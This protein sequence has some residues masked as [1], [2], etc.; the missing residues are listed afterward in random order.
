LAYPP[1]TGKPHPQIV[2]YTLEGD[3]TMALSKLQGKKVLLVHFASWSEE[4]R[5]K[6]PAWYEKTKQLV[7]DGKLVVLGVAHEQHA[8]RCR[9]FAQWKGINWPI[10]HDPLNLIRV[11][12]LPL[13]IGIDEHGIVR[14]DNLDLDTFEDT[15]VKKTYKAPKKPPAMGSDELPNTKVTRRTAKDGRSAK[16][17]RAHGDAL[18]LAGAAPQIDEAI[19]I[20]RNA[21]SMNADDADSQFRLGVT[22]RIRY[23]RPEH[24]PEDF[25]SAIDAWRKA[26]AM[27]PEN[28]VFTA[29]LLQYGPD[30]DK[31]SA[32]YTWVEAAEKAIKER[33]ETPIKL[34]VE[35][36]TMELARPS[37]KFGSSTDAA[38]KED[39]GDKA[40]KD[41]ENLVHLEYTIVRGMGDE[42]DR[43]AAV[44][45]TCRPDPIK[46]VRWDGSTP[47]RLWI[48]KPKSGKLSHEFVECEAG[49]Q[50]GLE[51]PRTLC[52][53]IELPKGAKTLPPIEAFA[54][55]TVR[56]GPEGQP[57]M[58]RQDIQIKSDKK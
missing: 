35:P 20:Y 14:A 39:P 18:V 27:Q 45:V 12:S 44:Y 43:L 8:D 40:K 4:S 46:A 11:D 24:K 10:V 52:F 33:G 9:L 22:Y 36:T 7:A 56:T 25:Q 29:R 32:Y 51:D 15:F 13:V 26:A 37:K 31:P 42:G 16:T 1:D 41:A 17:S 30:V 6:L 21:L 55:Y 3:H 23:D 50:A 49:P 57:Q 47:P 38:A 28:E 5:K 48:T 34:G 2:L 19:A 53:E 54:V 58:L